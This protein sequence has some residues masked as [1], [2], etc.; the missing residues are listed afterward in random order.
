MPALKLTLIKKL[1]DTIII[2]RIITITPIYGN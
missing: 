1:T 2:T